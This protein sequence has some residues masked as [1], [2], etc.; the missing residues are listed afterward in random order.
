MIHGKRTRLLFYGNCLGRGGAHQT[1]LAWFDLLGTDSTFDLDIWCASESWFTEQLR[2]RG[3]DY[4]LLPMPSALAKIRHGQWK[5]RLRTVAR[6]TSMAFGLARA[7]GRVLFHRPDVVVLTGGRDFIM[8]LPLVLLRRKH[9]VTVPQTTDW[10]EIP[11]C[12]LMCRLATKTYA[13]SEE[14]AQSIAQM[15]VPPE[16]IHVYPLIYTADHAGRYPDKTELRRALGLPISVP[17]LGVTGVVRPHKGQLDAIRVL[18]RVRQAIPHA[19]LLVVGSPPAG[20]ADAEAYY[21]ML[22][23]EVR[24]KKLEANVVFMGWRDDVPRVMRALDLLLVPSHDFEGVPRV[25]LEG[26]EAGLPIIAS[27]LPQFKEIIGRH[28]AGFLHPIDRLDRWATDAIH[29]LQSEARLAAASARSRTVWEQE[30]SREGVRPRVI[31]A[32]RDLAPSR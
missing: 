21:A 30:Y 1:M 13:I 4:K 22:Q 28:G 12:R 16:K 29:F 7:W 5:N 11:T 15:G 23:N 27:D 32:F 26:L 24:E 9:T 6:V 20:A 18:E 14:V 17:L 10:G 3:L 8:L 31:S 25:I 19:T 2:A